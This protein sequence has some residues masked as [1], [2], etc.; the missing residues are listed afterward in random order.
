MTKTKLGYFSVAVVHYLLMLI[1]QTN[2]S[3]SISLPSF[4]GDTQDAMPVACAIL[5]TSTRWRTRSY[6]I[7]LE[8]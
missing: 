5:E 4:I 7:D 2:H 6:K 3:K 8:I 1:K